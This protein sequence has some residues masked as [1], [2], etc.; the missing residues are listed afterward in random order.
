MNCCLIFCY[1]VKGVLVFE[2]LEYIDMMNRSLENIYCN[3]FNEY[4]VLDVLEKFLFV[5]SKFFYIFYLVNI[6]VFFFF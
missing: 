2:I 1:G 4:M 6:L 3:C 5:V